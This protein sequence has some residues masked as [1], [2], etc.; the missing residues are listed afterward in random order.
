MSSEFMTRL[1]TIL[2]RVNQGIVSKA[3]AY[4][5]IA[6]LYMRGLENETL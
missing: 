4:H 5:L 6:N 2:R 3:D 1:A